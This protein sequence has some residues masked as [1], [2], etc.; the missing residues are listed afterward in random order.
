MGWALTAAF[1]QSKNVKNEWLRWRSNGRLR[2]DRFR[3]KQFIE[4]SDLL[5]TSS[6]SWHHLLQSESNTSHSSEV[7]Q[8][9]PRRQ[10]AWIR[11]LSQQGMIVSKF[12]FV[13]IAHKQTIINFKIFKDA[14]LG[15]NLTR[16]LKWQG[17]WGTA[18]STQTVRNTHNPISRQIPHHTIQ[19]ITGW[20]HLLSHCVI[21]QRGIRIVKRTT[22]D[23]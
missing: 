5:K 3:S 4:I 19:K 6:A 17:S 14:A 11:T 21:N 16:R 7:P 23:N 20:G 10:T 1:L 9:N 8:T 13:F 12:I 2:Q 22:L 18:C 15:G